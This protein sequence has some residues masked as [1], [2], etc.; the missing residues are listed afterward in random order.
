MQLSEYRKL[1]SEVKKIA[2]RYMLAVA[3]ARLNVGT[4]NQLSKVIDE[5]KP[6]EMR[7]CSPSFLYNKWKTPIESHTK[8]APIEVLIPGIHCCLTSPLWQLFSGAAKTHSDINALLYQLDCRVTACLFEPNID[9]ANPIRSKKITKRHICI[10]ECFN[11]PDAL[12]CLLLLSLDNCPFQFIIEQATFRLFI[13]L[14]S[15]TPM[16]TIKYSLYILI[17]RTVYANS[18]R[19]FEDEHTLKLLYETANNARQLPACFNLFINMDSNE[20]EKITQYYQRITQEAV[21]CHLIKDDPNIRM[22]FSYLLNES[23]QAWI[24]IGL[25]DYQQ[26]PGKKLNPHLSRLLKRMRYLSRKY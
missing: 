12:A 4:L 25:Q 15:F 8:I 10:I 5:R 24:Q 1:P 19:V 26:N 20:L 7:G 14:V 9:M 18:K 3:M 21:T 16:Y 13:R 23:D 22:F 17:Q 2:T 6:K 11:T